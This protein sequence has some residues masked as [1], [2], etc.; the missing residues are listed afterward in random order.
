MIEPSAHRRFTNGESAEQ[1]SG[2][3]GIPMSESK[4]AY[5]WPPYTLSCAQGKRN[6][7]QRSLAKVASAR[8]HFY[9]AT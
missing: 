7:C 6:Q 4:S 2:E 3:L 1:L 5:E 8:G 9:Q